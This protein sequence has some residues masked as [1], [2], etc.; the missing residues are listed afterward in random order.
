[1]AVRIGVFH[2]VWQLKLGLSSILCL[3]QA[4]TGSLKKNRNVEVLPPYKVAISPE[5][6]KQMED[7]LQEMKLEAVDVDR[8]KQ[9]AK[10]INYY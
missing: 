9:N 10:V 6:E 1:M 5:L 2:I 4:F 3:L 8:A 7:L